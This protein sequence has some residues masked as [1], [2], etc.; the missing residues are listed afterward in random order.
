[1]WFILWLFP[2]FPCRFVGT[3]AT[4]E[5]NMAVMEVTLPSGFTVDGDALPSLRMSQN[6][7]RVETKNGDTV[8]VLYF[9]K[10]CRSLFQ[11]KIEYVSICRMMEKELLSFIK[12]WYLMNYLVYIIMWFIMKCWV[13]DKVFIP[14]LLFVQLSQ[15]QYNCMPNT[16]KYDGI[17]FPL[18]QLMHTFHTLW[19]S[20]IFTLILKTL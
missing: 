2:P 10:V 16:V 17:L 3:Q 9:D 1:V 19:K 14:F 5:S 4:N 20:P 11:W 8:V 7:K 18:F 15:W 6:V 12:V 13:A